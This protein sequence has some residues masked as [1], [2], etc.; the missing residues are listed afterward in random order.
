VRSSPGS[1]SGTWTASG[2]ACTPT[3]SA[4]CARSSGR[5]PRSS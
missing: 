3:T 5:S 4:T 2:S 1:S